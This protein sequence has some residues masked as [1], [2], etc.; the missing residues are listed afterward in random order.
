MPG[1]PSEFINAVL[2]VLMSRT[3]EDEGAQ[4]PGVKAFAGAKET[5]P[6]RSLNE[7]SGSFVGA[8]SHQKY[9]VCSVRDV[10]KQPFAA[11]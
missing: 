5:D 8:F 9:P 10:F 4:E 11:A 7:I 3:R 6:L 1:L 2:E